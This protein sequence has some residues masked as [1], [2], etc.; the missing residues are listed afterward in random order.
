[1]MI[2]LII[3]AFSARVCQLCKAEGTSCNQLMQLPTCKT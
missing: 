1:M 3:V 2:K